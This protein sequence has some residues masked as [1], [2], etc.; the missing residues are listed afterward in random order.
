[1]NVKVKKVEKKDIV[2]QDEEYT[3]FVITLDGEIKGTLTFDEEP[4][5]PIGEEFN[6]TLEPVQKKLGE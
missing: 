6:L 2:T 4:N 5:Y 1:M 3:K